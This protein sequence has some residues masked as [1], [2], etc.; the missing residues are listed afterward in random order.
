MLLVRPLLRAR[1]MRMM[2]GHR[3]MQRTFAIVIWLVLMIPSA[4]RAQGSWLQK[5]VSGVAA[6]ASVSHAGSTSI[7]GLRGGYSHQGILDVDLSLGWVDTNVA[8][9]PDLSVYALGVLLA[10][11]PVKQTREIPLSLS[12]GIGYE[13]DFF[14]SDTLRENDESVSQW[15]TTLIGGAYRFFPL[16]ERLG[17]TPQ[18]D[19][20]WLHSSFTDAVFDQSQTITDDQFV[21]TLKAEVAYLDSAG[22]IW[23]V[24]P[25]L[26]FGPGNTPTAFGL[27][28]T[29]IS[30][31]QGAR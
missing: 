30:T 14:S 31:I 25:G 21:I 29:F 13:Q 20:A 11:H 19:L 4:A 16:A 3:D 26:S 15:A 5:G 10:Y 7:F 9:L 24:A 8:D 22:H 1:P 6:E 28:V 12:V 2:I 27:S 18:I 23:G 17:V